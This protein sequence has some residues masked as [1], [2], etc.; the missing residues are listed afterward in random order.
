[1]TISCGGSGTFRYD[2]LYDW[3]ECVAPG[4]AR[5]MNLDNVQYSTTTRIMPKKM[6]DASSV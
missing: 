2:R 6:E 4:S 1:M 3:A 5:T